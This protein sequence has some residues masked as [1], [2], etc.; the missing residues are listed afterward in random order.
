MSRPLVDMIEN[1]ERLLNAHPYVQTCVW[2]LGLIVGAWLAGH[3]VRFILRHTITRMVERM[4]FFKGHDVEHAD[5]STRIASCIPAFLISSGIGAVPG[6]S[7]AFAAFVRNV[8]DAVIILFAAMAIVATLR[9]CG[10]IW[11]RRHDDSGR[12]IKGYV[13]IATIITYGVAIILMVAALIDRSPL[14]LLSGLGA[15]TAVLILVFQDTL[16]SFVAALELS[17]TEIVK[18]GDWIEMPAMNANGEVIDLSLYSVTVRN[19]DNTYSTF[20]LRKIVSEPFKNWRG[21]A[22]SGG[23][24]I[25]RA[26][27]IDQTTVRFLTE[28]DLEKFS[29]LRRLTEHIS[30]EKQAMAEWNAKLGDAAQVPGNQRRMTNLGL[31]RA[32]LENYLQDHPALRKDMTLMVRHLDPGPTGLP[33]QIYCFTNTTQWIA[34]EGIQADI[35]DHVIAMLPE[36]GLAVFQEN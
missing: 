24:R 10:Q 12:S 7:P 23:R 18:V 8:S 13:Q 6:I 36:F 9:L 3:V 17:S 25:I 34:Y 32:Y 28:E 16:L 2:F 1:L 20:P 14:I 19:W 30:R 5:I 31:L 4:R 26:I 27:P 21:M 35:F 11:Q 29:H 33:L 22:E 15:L